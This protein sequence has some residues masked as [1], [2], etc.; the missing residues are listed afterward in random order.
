MMVEAVIRWMFWMTG[1]LNFRPGWLSIRTM[2][3]NCR[4][5]TYSFSWTGNVSI[6]KSRKTTATATAAITSFLCFFIPLLLP[7][8]PR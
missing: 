2:R 1:I 5:A 7:S 3:P 6:P 8:P 4:T